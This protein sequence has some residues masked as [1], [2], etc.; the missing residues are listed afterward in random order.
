VSRNAAP[1]CP[2]LRGHSAARRTRC[3]FRSCWVSSSWLPLPAAG[4][5]LSMPHLRRQGTAIQLVVDGRAFLIRG[6]E[7]GNSS[8]SNPA[9][10]EPL[11]TRF[12]ALNMNTVLA[13]VYWDLVEPEEGR[14]DFSTLDRL[15][16]G[17]RANGMRLVLLWF[18]SWKNSMSCYAPAWV[19][20]DSQRFP[21]AADF[22]GTPQEILSPFSTVNRDTDARAFAA[23]LRHLVEIDGRAHAVVMV[24]VE[25]EVGMIPSA[26][27][28]SAEADRRRRCR[29]QEGAPAADVRERRPH[30]P[31]PPAGAGPERRA[32]APPHRRL[33][34]RRAE[35][36]LP[37]ARHLLPGL[38]RVGPALRAVGQPAVRPGGDGQ[39]GGLGQRALR[40]RRAR[41][42]RLLAVRHRD[43]RRA[44][45]GAPCGQLRPRGAARAPA[46]RPAGQGRVGGPAVGGAGAAAAPA[47]TAGDPPGR[48]TTRAGLFRPRGNFPPRIT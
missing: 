42:D 6:G 11:W 4:V 12:A 17:A 21:P 35:P 27:D 37:R 2:R 24:Q 15:I 10:L 34:R 5:D 45:R 18:G 46:G 14:F 33:A 31:G 28:H 32:L 26:R 23:V 47:G 43:D 22:D 44:R 48:A 1:G 7:L 8:A 39:P 19:K 30:P 3:S 9:F 13:P 20:G 29:R 25:N 40:T 38:R 16:D 41:R 36:R